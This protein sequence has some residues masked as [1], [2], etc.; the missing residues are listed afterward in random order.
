M[1]RIIFNSLIGISG[2]GAGFYFSYLYL[3][4]LGHLGKP[5]YL[6]LGLPLIIAGIIL[7]VRTSRQDETLVVR[8]FNTDPELK[9]ADA[10]PSSTQLDNV[11]EKNNRL[12]SDWIK[13]SDKRD[14]MKI[15][16]IAAAAEE[17]NEKKAK[18]GG[19]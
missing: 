14:K 13:E 7:L 15:L 10:D 8:T 12:V 2:T 19:G 6:L 18:L 4:S 5:L 16:E 9:A 11:V 1:F 17:D 3:E